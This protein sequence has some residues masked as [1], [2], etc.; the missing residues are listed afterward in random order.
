MNFYKHIRYFV[1]FLIL[2]YI[3][4][5]NTTVA[6]TNLNYPIKIS[7]VIYPPFPTSI[8]FLNNAITPSI[9][10]TITN[11]SSNASV[12]NVLLGVTIQSNIFNAQTRS[13][14]NTLPFTLFGNSPLQLS[15]LDF[16]SLYNFSNLSGITLAQYTSSFP[17]TTITYGFVLYDAVTKLQM[18]DMSNYKVTFAINNP[19]ILNGPLNKSV[20]IERGVQNIL[21]QWQPRQS[22]VTG[23]VQYTLQIIRL[24]D[25]TINP[26]LAF[27]GSPKFFFED[28]TTANTFNY[29]AF[30]PPLLSN[31]LYAWRVQAKAIDNGGFTS[32]TFSNNGYTNVESFKYVAECKAPTQLAGSDI[33]TTNATITWASFTNN[34]TFT[35]A[36]KPQSS[37]TWI[38]M[39]I[40]SNTLNNTFNLNRL[41]EGTNYNVKITGLCFGGLRAESVAYNFKTTSIS[42][43]VKALVTPTTTPSTSISAA[44]I[45]ASCGSKPVIT[46]IAQTNLATLADNDTFTA[47][48]YSIVVSSAR[49]SAGTFSGTGITDVWLNGKVFKLNVT[50]QNVRINADKKLVSGSINL[51]SANY[52]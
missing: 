37:S 3:S 7:P 14:N 43:S 42:D 38:D 45:K 51:V 28:S 29:N 36:Y 16:A 1:A 23:A 5:I 39:P 2:F 21:F 13:I 50:F 49:G 6:Q 34:Q 32:T 47:G 8:Q 26:Q 25:T 46:P 48:D 31:Q 20:I 17:Q 24:L 4:S 22:T 19:P 30:N 18:S 15:N 35:L 33:A 9:Y 44:T 12:Q 52:Q 11:K 40:P 27:T 41:T 10:I